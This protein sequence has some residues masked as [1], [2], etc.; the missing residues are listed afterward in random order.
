VDDEQAI[1]TSAIQGLI[2]AHGPRSLRVAILLVAVVMAAV[3]PASADTGPKP[4]MTFDFLMDVSGLK[5]TSGRLIECGDAHCHE[6][7]PL[8]AVGPQYFAC[9]D[10]A[11]GARA[12]GFSHFAYIEI[13]FSDHRT[14]RSDVFEDSAFDARYLVSVK[15]QA[16]VV[17]AAK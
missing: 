16:L 13:T 10:T 4:T 15:G 7:T 14:L 12:Y 9:G 3:A 17:T 2:T 6:A 1:E 11:C 8:R 5:I